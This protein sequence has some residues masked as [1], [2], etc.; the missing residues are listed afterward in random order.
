MGVQYDFEET[1]LNFQMFLNKGNTYTL[2]HL[3]ITCHFPLNHSHKTSLQ[4]II[5]M[6]KQV[7]RILNFGPQI[8]LLSNEVEM[9]RFRHLQSAEYL[10]L[11]TIPLTLKHKG[12]L[13]KG[14]ISWRLRFQPLFCCK[15]LSQIK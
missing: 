14:I 1:N 5:F 8:H 15:S 7:K 13:D 3:E 2:V 9:A 11:L 10:I 6:T 4:K 12:L